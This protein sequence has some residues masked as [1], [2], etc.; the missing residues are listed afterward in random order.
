MAKTLAGF[1]VSRS[2]ED[3]VITIEEEGG[4]TQEYTATYDQ[5][6]LIADTVGETL[7]SDEEDMLAVDDEGEAKD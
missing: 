7:D 5:L 1:T 6:D 3:Y 2:G 4:E